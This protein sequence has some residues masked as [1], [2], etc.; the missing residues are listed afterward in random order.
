VAAGEDLLTAK[1]RFLAPMCAS[2]LTGIV[3]GARNDNPAAGLLGAGNA[4]RIRAWESKPGGK[5]S[6]LPGKMHVPRTCNRHAEGFASGCGSMYR[7]RQMDTPKRFDI[8]IHVQPWQGMLWDPEP[9]IDL[10]VGELGATGV[11]LSIKAGETQEAIGL[12]IAGQALAVRLAPGAL[13]Q[14]DPGQYAS[15]RLRPQISAT[16]KGRQPVARL[17]AVCR[18]RSQVFR[19]RLSVLRDAALAGRHGDAVSCNALALPAVSDLCPSNGD[20]IEYIRCQLLDVRS[21]FEPDVIEIENLTWPD[22][23]RADRRSADTWPTPPGAVED[24]LLAICFC[25]SCRQ[26]AIQAG[27]DAA[28]AVRSVRVW[29]M[30]WLENERAYSGTIEDLLSQDAVL[31]EYVAC[32][33]KALLGALQ[34][35]ARSVPNLSLVVAKDPTV[36]PWN[37]SFEELAGVAGRLMV[38]IDPGVS[39][40]G[41]EYPGRGVADDRVCLEVAIDAASPALAGGPDIVRC[42]TDLARG[43]AA[44]IELENGLHVSPRRRPFIRQAIRAARRERV[45]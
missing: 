42:L 37:P 28:A 4:G 12:D 30:K 10:A 14:P 18:N 27:V 15:T 3:E 39:A 21:Q 17:A 9:L 25:P 20:V 19:L 26:Q 35:W 34:L 44:G 16:L 6:R 13:W 45:L 43:G 32:Q 1:S 24:G 29:L 8:L 41:C 7:F 33:Q 36:S 40:Q 23:Y 31:A 38:R 5:S 11:T 2:L 22:R